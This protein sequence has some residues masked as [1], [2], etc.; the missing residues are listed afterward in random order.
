[1]RAVTS[2]TRRAPALLLA[3]LTA[4]AGSLLWSAPAGAVPA[5][6]TKTVTYK[7][8]LNVL[9]LATAGAV[10][11]A[12]TSIVA[13]QSVAF[14]NTDG[15]TL[16]VTAL[17]SSKPA[18][19]VA[20]H[21]TSTP[22]VFP[23]AGIFVYSA[24]SAEKTLLGTVAPTETITVASPAAAST[25]APVSH[26]TSAAPTPHPTAAPTTTSGTTGSGGGSAAGGGSGA[27]GSS[28]SGGGATGSG[29]AGGAGVVPVTPAS[30]PPSLY[31]G[32]APGNFGAFGDLAPQAG[33]GGD[34]LP[35]VIAPYATVT[36]PDGVPST[37][38]ETY[39]PTPSPVAAVSSGI[40]GGGDGRAIGLTGAITA[41]LL[42]G[43]VASFGRLLLGHPA[44]A[45]RHR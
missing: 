1:M 9:G 15:A 14:A 25:P 20:P 21:A 40:G 8:S 36:G 18:A 29:G 42:V 2:L 26:P 5:A 16:T 33:V 19:T 11:P 37:L 13:G 3:L 23:S 44:A 27:G 41:V 6:A 32:F 45:G 12:F 17:G 30:T 28:G 39:T 34:V 24:S 35:P 22:I 31:G 10:T 43:L 38:Y 7:V 4:V